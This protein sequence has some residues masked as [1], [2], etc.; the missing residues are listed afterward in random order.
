MEKRVE[1]AESKKEST[2]R[3]SRWI[4]INE[5]YLRKRAYLGA[6]TGPGGTE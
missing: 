4:S 6:K 2:P 3:K 5:Y 1:I